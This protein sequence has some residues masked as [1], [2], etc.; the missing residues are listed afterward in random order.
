MSRRKFEQTKLTE[1]I[2]TALHAA[3]DAVVGRPG[4][5]SK[6]TWKKMCELIVRIETEHLD[7]SLKSRLE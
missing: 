4:T 5:I 1:L 7:V 3:G 2:L 6:E